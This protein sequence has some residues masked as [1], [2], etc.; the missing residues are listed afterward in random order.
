MAALSHVL[1]SFVCGGSCRKRR[2]DQRQAHAANPGGHVG[3]HHL[4]TTLAD[5]PPS[6]HAILC[7]A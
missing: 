4:L 5:L 6:N 7:L 2:V 1:A 3:C